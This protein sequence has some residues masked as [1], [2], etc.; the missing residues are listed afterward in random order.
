M[1]LQDRNVG[2]KKARI[3]RA[4]V[5]IANAHIDR[6]SGIESLAQLAPIE[7]PENAG[8][9]KHF[10]WWCGEARQLCERRLARENVGPIDLN[11]K[12]GAL[13][14]GCIVQPGITV[15]REMF[16]KGKDGRR[17]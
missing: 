17:F 13:R 5:I 1:R 9:I 16:L 6:L 8:G 4:I 14:I 2:I 10:L 15:Q 12:D 11:L 7:R 3:V